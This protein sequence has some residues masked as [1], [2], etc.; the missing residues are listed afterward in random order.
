MTCRHSKSVLIVPHPQFTIIEC[1]ECRA[2]K[3]AAPAGTLALK[4]PETASHAS[5]GDAVESV[6]DPAGGIAKAGQ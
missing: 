3:K 2:Q 1:R 6:V 5:I 4:S